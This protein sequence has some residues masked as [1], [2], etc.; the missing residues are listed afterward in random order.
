MAGQG[1]E[2]G[3]ALYAL[4]AIARRRGRGLHR[5]AGMH[6]LCC[7][8]LRSAGGIAVQGGGQPPGAVQQQVCLLLPQAP[9]VCWWMQR[10]PDWH[11]FVKQVGCVGAARC[12]CRVWCASLLV[13][14]CLLLCRWWW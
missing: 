13:Q 11:M 1:Q 7:W 9:S 4:R 5:P 6:E 3:W 8:R 12:G 14:G 2:R 10:L